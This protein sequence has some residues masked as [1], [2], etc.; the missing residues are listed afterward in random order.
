MNRIFAIFLVSYAALVLSIVLNVTFLSS[1][2]FQGLNF[3]Y[4][5][6]NAQPQEGVRAIQNLISYLSHPI[7]V[8]VVIIV[9]FLISKRRLLVIVHLLYYFFFTYLEAILVE[10]IQQTRPFWYDTRIK[11]L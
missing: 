11:F 2:F 7:L 10:G 8:A 5:Y 1:L 9:Y 3:I 4:S 6:Q